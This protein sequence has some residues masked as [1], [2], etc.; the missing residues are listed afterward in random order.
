MS[1]STKSRNAPTGP[2][3]FAIEA[4]ALPVEKF[5]DPEITARG[6]PRAHVPLFRLETDGVRAA[7]EYDAV[8]LEQ[9]VLA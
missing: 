3:P 1:T 9:E 4:A 5:S 7:A 2:S 8:L 6:E